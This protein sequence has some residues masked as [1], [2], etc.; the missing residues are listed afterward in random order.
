M[1]YKYNMDYKTR[2]EMLKLEYH[3]GNSENYDVAYFDGVTA[4]TLEK[5]VNMGYADPEEYQNSSPTIGEILK[6]MKENPSFTAHGYVVTPHRDDYR[7]S[8]EGVQGNSE[9]ECEIFNFINLFRH[10]DDFNFG[11][12]YQYAWY[13]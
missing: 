6:F 10:A 7:V 5:L 1:E 8:I 2:D 12:G 4:E 11:S 3:G 9:D 13:D